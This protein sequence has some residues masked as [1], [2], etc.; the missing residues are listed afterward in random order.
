M[1]YVE[2]TLLSGETVFYRT[3]LH[4]IVLIRHATIGLILSVVGIALLTGAFAGAAHEGKGALGMAGVLFLLGA[5]VSLGLGVVKRNATEIAVTNKRVLIKTGI[6]Q[7][8]TV[9]LLLSKIE[10]VGVDEPLLGRMLGY[11][12]VVVRGTGG[13]PELFDRITNPIEFRRQIQ[14][15]IEDVP[16][17]VRLG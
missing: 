7:R 17:A 12:S 15:R 5:A 11:G 16:A 13:T 10:S 3:R 1:G 9:E 2:R 4:W 8:R 6:F 14:G